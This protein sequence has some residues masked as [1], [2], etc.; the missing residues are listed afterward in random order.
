MKKAI[1]TLVSA[2][3]VVAISL[4]AVT[5]VLSIGMPAVDRAKDAALI[6]EAKG[7]MQNID[8]AAR[9]VLFDGNGAQRVFSISSTGGDYFVEKGTDSIMF[10]LNSISGVIDPGTYKREGNLLI[11]AGS[12]ANASVIQLTL[13]FNGTD[14]TGDA[15]WGKGTYLLSVRNDG[16]N[17]SSAKQNLAV[18]IVK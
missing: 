17:A 14:I 4:V 18:R 5:I 6:S 7:V 8:S 2:V 9:Q 12:G 13:Q 15:H 16:Y 3:M 1:S 11:T 10:R